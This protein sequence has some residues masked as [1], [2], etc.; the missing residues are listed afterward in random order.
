[1]PTKFTSL[2]VAGTATIATLVATAAT[3]T[4]GTFT[5]A[6]T[7]TLNATTVIST[8]L[9]GATLKVGSGATRDVLCKKSNGDVGWLTVSA[10]G[11]V[12]SGN[13]Q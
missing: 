8:T 2:G 1:M 12:V 4:T 7:T 13:C 10:T 6:N 5:T 9:S 3:L 11:T